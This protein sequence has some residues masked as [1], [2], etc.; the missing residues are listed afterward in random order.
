MSDKPVVFDEDNPEWTD[1]DF[2]RARPASELPPRVA[3]AFR[4][5]GRPS[6]SGKRAVSIRL[7]EDVLE[8]FRATGPGWQSRIN[9]VLKRAQ[10]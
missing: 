3:A 1:E 4:G 5:P 7:D 10:V 2:A 9:E 6:G 8:K